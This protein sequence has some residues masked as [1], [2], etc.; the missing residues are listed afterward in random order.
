[1]RL[2]YFDNGKALASI[3]GIFYHAGL[4][5]TVPWLINV[6]TESFNQGI[7]IFTFFSNLFRMPLFMF[8]AGYFA[9]YSV[10][11]YSFQDFLKNKLQRLGL[12]L[13]TSLL[14]LVFIQT[15]Y[16][17]VFFKKNLSINEAIHRIFPWDHNFTLSHLWFLYLVLLFSLI[18]YLVV[19]HLKSA[20]SIFN[21]F[22]TAQLN[23]N[24]F[25]ID[26]ILIMFILLSS[27]S[28]YIIELAF[29]IRHALLPFAAFGNY[30]PYFL[31]GILLH[32]NYNK[33]S[34][35]FLSY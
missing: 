9:I 11:K 27:V 33:Y 21:K 29:P 25:T 28:F 32:N 18:L 26:F 10:F 34:V 17:E 35:I 20:E 7:G 3:L 8:I 24:G 13:I 14:T 30:L 23:L 16:S 31:M 6:P 5:F 1:M 2:H 4:I 22:K 15:I 12:P 19:Y